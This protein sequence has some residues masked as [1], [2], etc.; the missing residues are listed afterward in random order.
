MSDPLRNTDEVMGMA[1]QSRTELGASDASA[2]FLQHAAEPLQL[3]PKRVAEATFGRTA[4][5]FKWQ[6]RRIHFG[7]DLREELVGEL[8]LED[9]SA[10]DWMSMPPVGKW[11]FPITGNGRL[12]DCAAPDCTQ[13]RRRAAKIVRGIAR[14]ACRLL[15]VNIT[16]SAWL[17]RARRGDDDSLA[18]HCVRKSVRT[19]A[20][21]FVHVRA[22]GQLA[23]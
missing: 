17:V 22:S 14:L 1:K 5:A 10:Q 19:S 20:R 12:R 3:S 9:I 15:D 8:G 6:R 4:F 16:D 11:P 23:G 13:C 7:L 2:S 18:P 21:R